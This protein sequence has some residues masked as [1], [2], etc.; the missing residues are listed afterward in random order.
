MASSNTSLSNS[1]TNIPPNVPP[2]NGSN[3]LF[4][5][6]WYMFFNN[7]KSVVQTSSGISLADVE[8][9]ILSMPNA[10]GDIDDLAAKI[11]N[12][13]SFINSIDMTKSQNLEQKINDLEATIQTSIDLNARLEQKINQLECLIQPDLSVKITELENKIKELEGY[14]HSVI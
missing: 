8:A 6:V 2:L 12:I 10:A 3:Q 13:D 1:I 9:L 11:N 7:I 14:V 5:Y 4:N